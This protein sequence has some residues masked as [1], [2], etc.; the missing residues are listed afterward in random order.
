MFVRSIALSCSVVLAFATSACAARGDLQRVAGLEHRGRTADGEIASLS[1]RV[2]AFERDVDAVLEL[3]GRANTELELATERYRTAQ[4]LGGTAAR[5]YE[6]AAREYELA[7]SR[8]RLVTIAILAAATW[9]YAGH[10][11]GTRMTTAQYRRSLRKQGVDLSGRDAD[12]GLP[13]SRGGADHPLNFEMIDS[14]LNRSLGNR[15]LQKLMTHPI[16]LLRGAAVSGLMRLRCSP[17]L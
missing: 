8:W 2:T 1:A 4:T 6:D 3:Y 16:H 7:A 15:V 14:G 12:H 9:D 13:R 5:A 17:Q 11:C 10:L